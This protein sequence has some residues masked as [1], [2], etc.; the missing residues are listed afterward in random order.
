MHT[1]ELLNNLITITFGILIIMSVAKNFRN[2]SDKFVQVFLA[3]S[4]LGLV[5]SWTL[6]FLR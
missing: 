3:F 2:R 6:N 5:L 4:I 1:V